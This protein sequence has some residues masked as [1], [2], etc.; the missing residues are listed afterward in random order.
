MGQGGGSTNWTAFWRCPAS[1]KHLTLESEP[2]WNETTSNQ[3]GWSTLDQ[4]RSSKSPV[5][6]HLLNNAHFANVQLLHTVM[7][8]QD[9][10]SYTKQYAISVG[11]TATLVW[12]CVHFRAREHHYLIDRKDDASALWKHYI[13]R[14]QEAPAP[15][16]F[17]IIATSLHTM[18]NW[19]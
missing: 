3:Q 13:H 1:T 6:S 19:D 9:H 7:T 15:L 8:V 2:P 18:I 14:H 10:M 5:Q 17:A 12:Y 16:R 11:G 4:K